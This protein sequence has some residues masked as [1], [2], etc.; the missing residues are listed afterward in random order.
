[1]AAAD[2]LVAMGRRIRE[3]RISMSLNQNDFGKLGGVGI[4]TQQQY[5]AGKTSPTAAYLYHLETHGVDICY[6]LTGRNADGA[7]AFADAQA[8]ELVEQLSDREREAVI[9][10][11][12][13]LAGRSVDADN[14]F[15]Q[16]KGSTR[17][18]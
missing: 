4:T 1:M 6:L 15:P 17:D 2:K 8:L 11:M 3:A 5:E 9:T 16:A 14:P 7:L 18:E 10:M 13:I 12:M